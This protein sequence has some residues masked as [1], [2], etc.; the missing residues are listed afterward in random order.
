[1]INYKFT[2]DSGSDCLVYGNNPAT[3]TI[4]YPNYPQWTAQVDL[5]ILE[6]SKGAVIA[7]ELANAMLSNYFVIYFVDPQNS[8][9][10]V[11]VQKAINNGYLFNGGYGQVTSQGI[12]DVCPQFKNICLCNDIA[13][14]D[15]LL[16]LVD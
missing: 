7:S 5:N 8:W 1:M 4:T 15:L 13:W 6:S 9:K 10:K 2:L 11:P 16:N 12:W 3:F 14:N